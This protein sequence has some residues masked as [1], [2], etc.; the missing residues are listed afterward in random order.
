MT[1]THTRTSLTH[2]LGCTLA[3][4]ALVAS[5]GACGSDGNSGD[6]VPASSAARSGQPNSPAATTAAPA[7]TAAASAA[8]TAAAPASPPGTF[9]DAGV[10]PTTRTSRDSVSSFALDV[11]TASWNVTKA[12]LDGGQLPPFEA[13]RTEEFVNAVGHGY[14]RAVDP[15]LTIHIDGTSVPFLAANQRVIRVGLQGQSVSNSRRKDANL[16]FVID[17]SGSMG[18]GGLETVQEALR[19]MV[20]NLNDEDQVAI[21]EFSDDASI[22]LEATPASEQRRILAAI[23]ELTPTNSTNAEAGLVL[24]YQLARE[25]FDPDKVNR[26]VLA[27]DGVANVGTTDADGIL[28]EIREAAGKGIN[29]VGIGVGLGSG[30]FNDPL[31]EEL[32]NKGD[33]FYTYIDSQETA[34][35]VFGRRLTSTLQTVAQDAKVEV[36]FNPDN[37]TKYRLLGYENREI[38]DGTVTDR[39][40]DG[41]ELGAGH[42]SVAL[43]EVTLADGASGELLSVLAAWTEPGT[44]TVVERTADFNADQLSRR[45]ESSPERLQSSV[46]VAAF[47]EQLRDAPWRDKVT[48]AEIADEA[49][50]LADETESDDLLEFADMANTAARL[51]R[52]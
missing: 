37:V 42:S 40:T 45:F 1:T 9:A 39:K 33:G 52:R 19:T 27:S 46:W 30:N 36:T 15:G 8:T 49:S 31:L 4:A 44:R 38:A 22:V 26:V 11:D 17:T 23:D 21:V 34:N 29:L 6:A 28:R 5:L 13:V 18:G 43:Y 14:E 51:S 12:L 25:T 35:E 32:T 47:A 7:T 50:F 2:R 10:N 3:A 41:G 24:G 16:T 48:L 20:E